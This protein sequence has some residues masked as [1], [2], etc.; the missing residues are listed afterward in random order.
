MPRSGHS[1]QRSSLWLKRTTSGSPTETSA[2]SSCFRASSMRLAV[3]CIRQHANLT[4]VSSGTS[5]AV[6]GTETGQVFEQAVTITTAENGSL[7]ARRIVLR[8]NKPTRDGDAE[9]AILTNLPKSALAHRLDV[10]RAARLPRG[11]LRPRTPCRPHPRTTRKCPPACAGADRTRV[12]CRHLSTTARRGAAHGGTTASADT[13]GFAEKARVSASHRGGG[14]VKGSPMTGHD[15]RT[16]ATHAADRRGTVDRLV[17]RRPGAIGE[18][19]SI[20]PVVRG[21]CSLI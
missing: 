6:G 11:P 2:R 12:S 15:S 21:S 19:W 16:T 20:V 9:M 1:P 17:D 14:I 3:F 7:K 18:R 10:G 5:R 4:V 8:L 13:R